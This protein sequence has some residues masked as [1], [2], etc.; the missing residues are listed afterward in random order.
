MLDSASSCY[1]NQTNGLA[2]WLRLWIQLQLR[3]NYSFF[4]FFRIELYTISFFMWDYTD[5]QK[6]RWMTQ[7]EA[8]TA[9][10]EYEAIGNQ[11]KR[12]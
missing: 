5:N 7:A 6:G 11:V 10:E 4:I 3:N 9:V 12:A 1:Y 2:L 8:Y